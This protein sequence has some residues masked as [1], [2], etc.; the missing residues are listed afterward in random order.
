MLMSRVENYF[1]FFNAV[2]GR[3]VVVET[4]HVTSDIYSE[5]ISY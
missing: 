2:S 5:N 1:P 4:G 3:S